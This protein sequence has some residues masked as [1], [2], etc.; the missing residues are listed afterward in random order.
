MNSGVFSVNSEQI[1]YI[2]PVFPFVDFEQV[3][4]G[5]ETT[6]TFRLFYLTHLF[7]MHPFSTT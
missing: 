1:P 6:T 7:P 2:V 5:W 3:N 4:A